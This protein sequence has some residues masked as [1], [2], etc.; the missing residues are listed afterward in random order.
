MVLTTIRLSSEPQMVTGI[1]CQVDLSPEPGLTS[2]A[3]NLVPTM[4]G[5]SGQL[6]QTGNTVNGPILKH[7][8]L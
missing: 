5:V 7:S 6:V 4:S 3:C 2:M 8:L 1:Y